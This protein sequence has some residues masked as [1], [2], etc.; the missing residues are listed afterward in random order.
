MFDWSDYMYNTNYAMTVK[1]SED[2]DTED[3]ITKAVMIC[4]GKVIDKEFTCNPY[5]EKCIKVL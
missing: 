5:E 2:N 4:D 3:Q 1:D